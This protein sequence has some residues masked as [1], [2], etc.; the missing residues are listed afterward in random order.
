MMNQT[1]SS[2]SG[3][4]A[5]TLRIGYARVSTHDQDLSLQLDALSKA[6]CQRIYSEVVSSKRTMPNRPE[7]DECLRMLRAGDTLTVWRLDRLGR[8]LNDLVNIVNDLQDRDIYFESLTERI[9]TK[10]AGGKLTFHIFAALAE[11]ER[12][13]IRERTLAGLAAARARGRKGGRK[14]K[15]TEKMKR[16]MK[17]LY[18]SKNVSINDIVSRYGISKASFYRAVLERDYYNLKQKQTKT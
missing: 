17:A 4:A 8:S 18:D 10:S 12:N 6:G 7:L 9:E 5:S 16:E 3:Q 2:S 14:P 1:P 13:I 11:F 15:I